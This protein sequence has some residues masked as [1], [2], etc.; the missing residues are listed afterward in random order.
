MAFR[1]AA[2]RGPAR[3]HPCDVFG[4]IHISKDPYLAQF[5][6]FVETEAD[7]RADVI[8]F[9]ENNQLYAD[10][11]GIWF[12]TDKR[13]FATYTVAYVTDRSQADFIVYFTEKE[14]FAGCNRR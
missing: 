2:P 11:Q 14:N 9:K 7:Y 5:R 6:V 4:V 12:V 1:P 3:V 10:R 8:V 13:G